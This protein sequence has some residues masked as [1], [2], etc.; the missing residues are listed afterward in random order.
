MNKTAKLLAAPTDSDY[1]VGVDD[2][3]AMTK[4]VVMR[5]RRLV[6]TIA[7]P[8]RA[9]S[10]VHTTSSIGGADD[11]LVPCYE[12]ECVKFT[13]ADLPDA[14]SARFEDYPF[15]GMNRAIVH[16]ALRKAGLGGKAVRI[17]TGLPLSA[18]YKGSEPNVDVIKRKNA[19]ITTK[20][21]CIDGSPM[22]TIASHSV[23]PEGLAAWV[24]YAIGDD[25][26]LR[27]PAD[28]TVGVIDIGGR[29]TD[30]AVVLPGRRIDHARCGSADI[31][32]LNVVEQVRLA[33]L[34]RF[35]V[36]IPGSTIEAGCRT[37]SI[38]MWGK[39][40][41]IRKEVEAAVGQTMDG[42]WREA[43]RRLG[44]AVDIDQILL[45]GGGVHL[46]REMAKRYP[47]IQVVDQPE[48][49]NA[50]GFAKYLSL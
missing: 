33:L 29:T 9:R 10:G 40:H 12:T 19:S 44:R 39:P 17:A 4:L 26:K 49:A 42:V 5:G 14:E 30:V 46:F 48:F 35:Q 45:V 31:G 6:S 2:G 11:E 43:N 50:R 28:I 18:F 13:V 25:G 34:Q 36:E 24:D 47:N 23:F 37:G 41:D 8:S 16:H 15:S 3:Y 1:V 32:A 22:A 20:V 21:S 38:R 27:I 7:I